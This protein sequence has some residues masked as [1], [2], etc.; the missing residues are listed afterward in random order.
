MILGFQQDRIL[1]HSLG[2]NRRSAEYSSQIEVDSHAK[3]RQQN[4]GDDKN[5]YDRYLI[6]ILTPFILDDL[7]TKFLGHNNSLFCGAVFMSPD[8]LV[9]S[10]LGKVYRTIRG[11]PTKAI[12]RR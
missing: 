7:S 1:L 4:Y 11:I 12:L 10:P 2:R 8:S 3:E 6:K 5:H 9:L